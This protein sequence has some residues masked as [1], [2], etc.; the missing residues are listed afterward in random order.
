MSAATSSASEL[1][2]AYFKALEE[3][4]IRLRGAPL[5]LS[6]ADW[7]VAKAWREEGI[8]IELVVRVM[9]RIFERQGDS[10]KRAG[11][12]S[13]RYFRKAV[14]GAWRQIRE[15]GAGEPEE[16][17]AEPIDIPARLQRLA[18][19]LPSPK[20]LLKETADPTDSLR[21]AL[22]K[23]TEGVAER[24]TSLAGEPRRV[25]EELQR[26]DREVMARLR[27]GL[28]AETLARLEASV[29]ERLAVLAGRLG[30]DSRDQ[31]LELL[32]R[33]RLRE[34]LN[35]PVLSLFSPESRASS[36]KA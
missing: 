32:L 31:T 12:R 7:Q 6:P 2:H 3:A 26:L 22:V 1:N 10:E 15:L 11:I 35:L 20:D 18:A 28:D 24:V 9:E 21:L 33:R 27:E 30:D 5:L 29:E 25:E 16:L 36:K 13:L 19:A 8:P 34:E 17:G 4:F 14:Q 23:A